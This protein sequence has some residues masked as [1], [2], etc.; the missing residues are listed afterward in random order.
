MTIKL[1]AQLETYLTKMLSVHQLM[2]QS[3]INK[4]NLLLLKMIQLTSKIP[5]PPLWFKLM[6][7]LLMLMILEED[8]SQQRRIL[9]M[10]KL[11]QLIQSQELK[12]FLDLLQMSEENLKTFKQE[13]EHVLIKSLVFKQLL[14]PLKEINI[15]ELEEILMNQMPK[16]QSAEQEFLKLML[17]LLPPQAHL[18]ILELNQLKLLMI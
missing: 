18:Q 3:T 12:F 14:T 10:P 17:L 15:Q 9:L 6:E 11:D 13:L 16:S 2:T 5:E 4:E 1:L 7:K 8:F